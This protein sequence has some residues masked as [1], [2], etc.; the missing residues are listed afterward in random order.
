MIIYIYAKASY[1]KTFESISD[2]NDINSR[3]SIENNRLKLSPQSLD[4]VWLLA[5][6]RQQ[7][8]RYQQILSLFLRPK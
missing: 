5:K 7:L 4:N 3:I 6:I 1:N 8:L 2:K